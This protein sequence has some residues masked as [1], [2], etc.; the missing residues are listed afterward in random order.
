[1][2]TLRSLLALI[3]AWLLSGGAAAYPGADA[4]PKPFQPAR[5]RPAPLA[6]L[7]LLPPTAVFD[8]LREAGVPSSQF[9]FHVRRVDAPRAVAALNDEQPIVLASTAKIVTTLAALDLLGPEHRWTTR[10]LARGEVVDGRLEGDLL[11]V[12]G[13]DASLTSDALRRWF[14][15]LQADGLREI[16]GDIVLD[17]LAFRLSPDD[18]ARTPQPDPERPHHAWPDALP[19]DAGVLRVVVSPQGQGKVALRMQPVLDGVQLVSA[20]ASGPGCQAQAELAGPLTL[21][22]SGMLAP[23]CGERRVELMPLSHAEFGARAIAA[24]WV[25]AGGTLTGQVVERGAA[26]ETAADAT[27]LAVLESE[28]LPARVREINKLSHNLLARNLWLTLSPEFPRR[29]ATSAAAR[30]RVQ[31]WLQTQGLKADDMELDTGSGLSRGER[32]RPRALAQ[33]LARAWRGPHAQAFVASLPVAGV[34]GTLARRFLTGPAT[35]HAWLKTGSLLDARALAG[36]V[37]GRSGKVYALAAMIHH[38]DAAAAAPALDTL[39]EWI[40]E[41]G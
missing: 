2:R 29:S 5:G 35:G 25:E 34:D 9:A 40:A 3:T 13:G 17:R 7:K 31:A 6:G 10:A 36:Y 12:G 37:K 19:L 11:I 39:V 20:V 15:R 30:E 21:K 4:G 26:D 28:P 27:P 41:N 24:L 33:L 38:P 18:L 22:V 14:A 23:E 8:R 16:H 1:M 32:A